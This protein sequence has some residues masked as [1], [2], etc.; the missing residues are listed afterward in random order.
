MPIVAFVLAFFGVRLLLRL[1]G[2]VLY[3]FGFMFGYVSETSKTSPLK[4]IGLVLG[5][6]LCLFVFM[7]L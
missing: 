6:L 3:A 4:A 2:R 5:G 7:H 1:L